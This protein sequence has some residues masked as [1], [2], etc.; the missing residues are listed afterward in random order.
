MSE[1]V[2]IVLPT[3]NGA[4]YIGDSIE[5]CLRQTYE[6]VE[7][8]IVDDGSTDGTAAIA[9]RFRDARVRRIAKQR[10]EGL[11][12]AL[13]TGFAVALGGYLTWT[14]DDNLY[15]PEAIETMVSFL[16]AHREAALV[17][18]GYRLIDAAGKVL[19]PRFPAAPAL[20]P[21]WNVVGSCFL[22]RR[23]VHNVV[24]GYDPAFRFAEDYE[25][26]VRVAER[27]AIAPLP[28]VL[29]SHRVHP[30]SLTATRRHAIESASRRVRRRARRR[31]PA[32]RRVVEGIADSGM[33]ELIVQH[34]GPVRGPLRLLSRLLRRV[35]VR[36]ARA[37]HSVIR[38]ASEEPAD[39]TQN[40]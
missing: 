36:A 23:A 25:Y 16:D 20:L 21:Y 22:Y 2:S 7:L 29:Y 3:R 24:G 26:W 8:V 37:D 39:R 27:F 19:E 10:S 18:A 28:K 34:C 38:P 31:W 11:P 1:L 13:N 30:E 32:A 12:E 33:A 15:D 6:N 35:D 4:R 14:S 17:Y 40:R 9:R 5:S